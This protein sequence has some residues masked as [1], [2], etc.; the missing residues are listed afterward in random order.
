[1]H[2]IINLGFKEYLHS[3]RPAFSASLLMAIGMIA[4]QYIFN[5]FSQIPDIGLLIVEILFGAGIYIG[6]LKISKSPVLDEMI[7]LFQEMLKPYGKSL[8][9]RVLSG[10]KKAS[11]S[12]SYH[13]QV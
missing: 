13:N 8:S 4:V 3:L 2:Q 1:V 7:Y 9:L 11:H 10:N 5:T 12:N 6:T